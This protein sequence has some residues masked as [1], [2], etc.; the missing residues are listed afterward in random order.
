MFLVPQTNQVTFPLSLL[1]HART[2]LSMTRD[3]LIEQGTQIFISNEVGPI[4]M[5]LDYSDSRAE[6]RPAMAHA[7]TA[8]RNGA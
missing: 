4:K 5:V 7:L 3:W 2:Q 8:P 1:L 6:A